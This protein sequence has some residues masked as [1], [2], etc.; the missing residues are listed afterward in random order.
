MPKFSK[1]EREI[2]EAFERGEL[3]SVRDKTAELKD[4]REIAA[5]TFRKDSRVNIR[6][7]GKDLRAL[8]KL[9]VREGIPYQTLIASVLHKYVDGRLREDG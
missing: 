2:V 6:I 8:R 9:A 7:S 3:Q 5:A 1:E 4:H